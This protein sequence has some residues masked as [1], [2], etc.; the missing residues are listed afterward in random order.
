MGR[1]APGGDALAQCA[2]VARGAD[3]LW[4]YPSIRAVGGPQTRH[5]R[6]AGG[7]VWVYGTDAGRFEGQHGA[8]MLVRDA[9]YENNALPFYNASS[10]HGT[11]TIDNMFCANFDHPRLAGSSPTYAF[12]DFTGRFVALN[13]QYTRP[14]PKPADEKML[15][16]AGDCAGGEVLT[17]NTHEPASFFPDAPSGVRAVHVNVH[18]SKGKDGQL[19]TLGGAAETEWVA[20]MLSHTLHATPIAALTTL[21]EGVTDVR[22]FRVVTHDGRIGVHLQR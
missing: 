13:H 9:W 11:L 15:G 20:S 4:P 2:A 18:A 22:L 19:G 21:P 5:R 3:R 7:G 10:G 14:Y 8:R 6:T 16:F 12:T 1:P 17:L